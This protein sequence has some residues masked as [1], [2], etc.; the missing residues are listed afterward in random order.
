MNSLSKQVPAA[1]ERQDPNLTP[2]E[3]ALNP[4]AS[5]SAGAAPGIID[6]GEEASN[7]RWVR[8]G[9]GERSVWFSWKEF[10]KDPALVYGR[11]S[12]VGG[13][14]FTHASRTQFSKLIE[15]LTYRP[16]K[17][18]A[19]PGWHH[20][21]FVMGDG[22]VIPRDRAED[23]VVTFEG[24]PKFRRR[25]NL[26]RWKGGLE[27]VIEDQPIILFALAY[28]FVPP[29]LGIVPSDYT[30]PQLELVGRSE[31][32]KSTIATLAGSVWAGDRG[33]GVGG[34]ESWDTTLN[35]FEEDK[36]RHAGAL[37]VLD[38]L[39]LAGGSEREQAELIYRVVFK[40]E[41]TG[42]RRRF[43]DAKPIEH[44]RFALLST[45]NQPLVDLLKGVY[46]PN[47]KA[48]QS[49][50]T[51]IPVDGPHGV[52]SSVPHGF[53]TAA[54]AIEHLRSVADR[55]YGSAGRAFVKM[56]VAHLDKD[57]TGFKLELRRRLDIYRALYPDGAARP[58][59]LFALTAVAG[60]LAAEWRILP[61]DPEDVVAAVRT[62]HDGV[63]GKFPA[64]PIA[65]PVDRM[66]AYVRKHRRKLR[67]LSTIKT[68]LPRKEFAQAAG[69]IGRSRD[70]AEL[71]VSTDRFK[72]EFADARDLMTALR[73][74]SLART[75][76]GK[77][78]KL[79]VKVP[80]SLCPGAR[81]C[82]IL[83]DPE[84]LDRAL[85]RKVPSA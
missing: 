85:G 14:F 9:N 22:E 61:A 21:I 68:P 26:K 59:K 19:T 78:K 11:L 40:A 55:A 77:K 58:T 1:A 80:L 36:R 64:T 31:C 27:A 15:Q 72:A 5:P 23:V 8:Y 84:K 50:M 69:F 63:L 54:G 45:S 42:G 28:A 25:G 17:V 33:S 12:D 10:Q 29:L 43:G 32:G 3:Q 65:D 60:Q 51:T 56:L 53:A 38:E 70:K 81:A 66:L 48:A 74:A 4:D 67:E 79:S 13:A 52:L 34:A 73:L 16:I 7:L 46:A 71:L 83:L 76:G 37:L 62:V 75:E 6:A 82:C 39:N 20:G 2:S 49:R 57:P 35:A 47:R 44:V 24:Q 18:G 30:N 41:A